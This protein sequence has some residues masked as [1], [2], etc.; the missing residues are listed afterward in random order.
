M[1]YDAKMKMRKQ[2][3]ESGKITIIRKPG[4]ALMGVT[5]KGT[6]AGNG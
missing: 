4:L 5:S 1:H 2:L 6:Y 3:A